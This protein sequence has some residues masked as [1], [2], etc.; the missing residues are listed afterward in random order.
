MTKLVFLVTATAILMVATPVSA[1]VTVPVRDD[2]PAQQLQPG[3]PPSAT[4]ALI[5]AIVP[6]PVKHY[7]LR[8]V[9]P[10][11]ATPEPATWAM[12]TIGFG[13]IG[14]AIRRRRKSINQAT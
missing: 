8:Q 10:S 6:A 12:M 3:A 2:P 13:A 11:Q 4:A 5:D 1:T 7:V 14:I 9:S